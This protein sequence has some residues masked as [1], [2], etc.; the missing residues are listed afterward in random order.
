MLMIREKRIE[1]R[2]EMKK[3]A[4]EFKMLV[5]GEHGL[6]IEFGTVIS[7]EINVL[8]QQMSR[9][10][11][12]KK[13]KGIIEIVPTYRSVTVY[14]DP[15]IITRQDLSQFIIEIFSEIRQQDVESLSPKIVH[16]PVCY[17]GVLG[18]DIELVA[19]YTGLSA[20]KM[21][22]IHTSK[23][24]LVYMLGFIPGFPYLGGLPSQLAV[25]R[26]VKPRTK[27]PAGSVGIGGSQT[28]FYPIESSGEWWLIGRT[29]IKAFNPKSSNPFLFSPGD[30][31]HF[32]EISIDEY[33]TVRREVEADKYVPRVSYICNGR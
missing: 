22:T 21:I 14:F 13:I 10:L 6:V 16:V 32:V 33:F 8:V 19:R 27:I 25:P 15:L 18:P 20:Q 1:V 28:G 26:Q 30:Y 23:P 17:G 29:P 3:Y 5:A 24:Y 12:I 7:P 2:N 9:L 11:Q 31:L 4:S